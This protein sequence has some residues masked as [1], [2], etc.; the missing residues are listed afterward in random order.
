MSE[1]F[2]GAAGAERLEVGPNRAIWFSC[3]KNLYDN[4][5]FQGYCQDFDEFVETICNDRSRTKG[6]K[7]I[8]GPMTWGP[9][10]H[11]GKH[12]GDAY[13]R[14][15]RR[16]WGLHI[17]CFDCDWFASPEAF[18]AFRAAVMKWNCVVYTTASHTDESPRARA[19]VEISRPVT[20][21]GGIRLGRQVQRH[22]EK[23]VGD[24]AVKFDPSVYRAEQP[25]F[26]PLVGA[27]VWRFHGEPLDAEKAF[28]DA[29]GDEP[30]APNNTQ[31]PSI[32]AHLVDGGGFSW[33]SDGDVGEGARNETMLRY[34]GYLRGR[35]LREPEIVALALAENRQ[36][37][38]PP[39]PEEEVR[40]ICGRF[41][42]QNRNLQL[43]HPRAP[44]NF[45]LRDG[46]VTVPEQPPPP[47][48]YVLGKQ[49]TSGTVCTLGGTGGVSKTMLLMQVAVAAATGRPVLGDLRVAEGASL[50]F[51]GEEDAAERDRR[52][53][54]ICAHFQAD[55]T[56]VAHR[57]KCFPAAGMDIRL[58]HLVENNPEETCL[59]ADII[60]LAQ[61]T[62]RSAGVPVKFIVFDHARLVLGG[63]PNSAEHVTQLTRVLTHIAT[64]T[65]AAVFLLAHSPKSAL[66]KEGD[67]MGVADIAGSSAFADNAR[68]AF[69]LWTM[70]Q[71]EAK[72]HHVTQQDRT[73]YVRVQNVKANYGPQGDGHWFKRQRI[74]GWD[75][76]VLEHVRLYTPLAFEGKGKSELRE[77][78]LDLVRRRPGALSERKVR[79]FAGK[80]GDLQASE[81]KVRAEVEAMIEEGLLVSRP[82]TPDERRK[83][84]LTGQVRE[85]LDVTDPESLSG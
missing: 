68:S 70:R 36:R 51:L 1:Y 54:A 20:R 45:N 52:F 2:D 14:C 62:H 5:P 30:V 12:E 47:R 58:T 8:C 49:V 39:L 83:F 43:S 76:A 72:S 46:D 61:E 34:A 21:A 32:L 27:Q 85:V 50:L 84:R 29:D 22:I 40:D 7:Y 3:G 11:P 10:E 33:P 25:V 60:R 28:A 19:I 82:P 23:E 35:G 26:T 48:D 67:E 71:K 24:D 37:F 77:R 75:V 16:S 44:G 31:A 41:S 63:D 81:M 69:M 65:G 53:G 38:L 15:A 4:A 6:Q 79:D 13:W 74:L 66:A 42:H 73:A 57:V 9:H 17:L 64:V 78:I 55:L 59:A 56:L 18:A 80:D